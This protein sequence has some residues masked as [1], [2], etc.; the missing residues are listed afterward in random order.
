MNKY[1]AD[2]PRADKRN[3]LGFWC[4]AEERS[5][6][7]VWMTG[8]VSPGVVLLMKSGWVGHLPSAAICV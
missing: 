2:K 7:W 5:Y 4:V 1:R 8:S 6:D 3:A